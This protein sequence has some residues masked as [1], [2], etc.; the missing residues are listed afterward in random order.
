MNPIKQWRE[1]NG[2][3]YDE[4]AGMLDMSPMNVRR[5]AKLSNESLVRT[6]LTT[7]EKILKELGI[8][9]RDLI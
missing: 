6:P 7:A 2:K 9:L 3:S 5:L 4:M 8:D 1:K